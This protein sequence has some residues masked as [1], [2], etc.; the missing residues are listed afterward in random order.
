MR[1]PAY[2]G[3]VTDDIP[4]LTLQTFAK[5]FFAQGQKYGFRF[6]DYV[7]FV[8]ILLDVA[9][10]GAGKMGFEDHGPLPL[11]GDGIVIRGFIPEDRP[12]F[13]QW[14]SDKSG[15]HFLLSRSTGK[16]IN[17]DEL[18]DDPKNIVGIIATTDGLPI[19]SVAFLQ[20]DPLQHK[21]ELRKIVGNP[22]MRGKGI[23]KEATCLWVGHGLQT[24][25]LK[26]IYLYT[27]A[28]NLHNI[29]LNQR[30]GFRMEGLLRN[31]VLLDGTYHDVLRMG[32]IAESSETKAST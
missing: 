4:D 25:G 22:T 24:L 19:G 20:H 1:R 10:E 11:Q 28:S 31:E 3:A 26:K 12:L 21:A 27:L 30:L 9:M 18:L 32:L 16:S 23:G 5:S 15:R 8:N 6:E 14:L 2:N 17:V 7:R 13:H 29:K